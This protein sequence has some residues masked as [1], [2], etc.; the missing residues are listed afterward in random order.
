[1]FLTELERFIEEDIGYND[2]SCSIIPDHKVEAKV[3]SREDG[4]VSGLSEAM[5]IFASL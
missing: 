3:I 2:I 5:Q 4:V 1:M